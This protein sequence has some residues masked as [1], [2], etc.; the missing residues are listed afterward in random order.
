M[1]RGIHQAHALEELATECPVSEYGGGQQDLFGEGS[2]Y[3]TPVAVENLR[4]LAERQ[5]GDT[6]A[7]PEDKATRCL[8]KAAA[9]AEAEARLDAGD[10]AARAK[11]DALLKALF[12]EIKSEF[13][14]AELLAPLL[15]RTGDF[16]RSKTSAPRQALPYYEEALRRG[17]PGSHF[18]AL[19]GR[20]TVLAEGS[21]DEQGG[22]LQ[23]LEKVFAES[24]AVVLALPLTKETRHVIGARALRALRPS[25]FLMNVSRGGIVDEEALIELLRER[26][27]A[28]AVLDVFEDEP[29]PPGSPFWTL[30]NVVVT[31]H[32]SSELDGWQVELARIFCR[33]LRHWMNDEPLENVVDPA[34]GY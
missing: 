16:L 24:D 11:A 15:L 10:E 25:A 6:V 29:L 8:L 7:S 1:Q 23:D 19:L 17:E 5:L 21:K 14:P 26:R 20:A 4:M 9:A 18:A 27:I 22:A 3:P 33:N 28:G 13:T 31:P 30:P 34:A 32:I 12:Q 2:G